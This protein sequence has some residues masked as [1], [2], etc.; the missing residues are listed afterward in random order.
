MQKVFDEVGTLDKKCYE[1][2]GLTEDILMEHAASS[3]LNFIEDN[4]KKKSSVL[5]SSGTGNNGADG[6]TLA[7][8]LQGAYDVTL[9]LPFSRKSDMS[10]LQLKR[11]K[12]IDINTVDTI[13]EKNYDIVVDCLF[14]SG[15]TR[16]LNEA[17]QIIIRQL[18]QLS[19]YKLACDIPSGINNKGQVNTE[20]FN[21]HTTI[22]MGALKKS[23][24]T[25]EAKEYTG[26][27]KVINLGV[28]RDLYENKSNCFLLDIEDI[29][30]PLRDKKT[31]HKGTYGHLCVIGG[32][33]SGAALIS[34]T[35]GFA[36]GAGL[37]TVICDDKNLPMEIMSSNTLPSTTTAIAAGMGLGREYNKTLLE[38]NIAKIIDADLF[39]DKNI[40]N[41]LDQNN[42]VLTPHPKE[43]CS[44]LKICGI[45]DIDISTLQKNRF[46]YVEK[47]CTNYPKSVL[48]LKG[49]N[50]I[51]GQND[52]LYINP[53]GSSKLS[54]GGSGDVLSGLIGALL[55]QGY[56]PI[57]AAINATLA[58]SKAA[59]HY[60]KN[61]YSLTPSD[62]IER[63]K[64]I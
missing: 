10:E 14:G 11:A 47:F 62:L 32:E 55:A 57:N 16:D 48:L 15:L 41:F 30:L 5:I 37:V 27:I 51:V 24:F 9:H 18:N 7:R 13:P 38:N 44:L 29:D 50:V 43:F 52:K 23:L 53:H 46:Y 61:N 6:I 39:Y 60:D 26:D 54:F 17:S 2:Y 40:L 28:Q 21:A 1:Q 64:E 35:A 36:F 22:T 19:G 25:D 34:A 4:F 45:D 3:M 31:T 63:I 58:H 56:S 42:I 59:L 8:L 20:V 12:L 49:S 33:K